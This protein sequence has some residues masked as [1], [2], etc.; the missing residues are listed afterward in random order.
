MSNFKIIETGTVPE[1]V[2]LGCMV[3]CAL[4]KCLFKYPLDQ[5]VEHRDCDYDLDHYRVKCPMNGC[6]AEVVT[7]YHGLS[8]SN[9]RSPGDV[10]DGKRWITF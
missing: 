3:R 2:T 9:P 4:C 10:W 8:D 1:C 7:S 6:P 5:R